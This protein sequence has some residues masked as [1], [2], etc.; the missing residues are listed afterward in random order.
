MSR[1]RSKL[2]LLSLFIY[3]RSP[4]DA[5]PKLN[6]GKICLTMVL[7]LHRSCMK[8]G[9]DGPDALRKDL[10]VVTAPNHVKSLSRKPVSKYCS[11]RRL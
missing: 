5:V 4:S 3:S 11:A 7:K 10:S 2:W 1:A 6:I 9:R 8:L